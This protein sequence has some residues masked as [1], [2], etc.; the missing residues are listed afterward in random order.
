MVL[1]NIQYIDKT[2]KT[3]LKNY[4]KTFWYFLK[5]CYSNNVTKIKV[6]NAKMDFY[7]MIKKQM[8]TTQHT[9]AYYDNNTNK[10]HVIVVNAN[11]L[12][13]AKKIVKMQHENITILD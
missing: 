11:T 9:I 7:K 6:G 4:A 3:F 5:L 1:Y 13:D 10:T 2:S 8:A 12:Q